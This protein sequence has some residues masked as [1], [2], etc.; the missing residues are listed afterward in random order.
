[1]RCRAKNTQR[2]ETE[3]ET[4]GIFSLFP[5]LSILCSAYT[6][7]IWKKRKKK[8]KSFFYSFIY[9]KCVQNVLLATPFKFLR[10]SDWEA[11]TNERTEWQAAT[12]SRHVCARIWNGY[13]SLA[14]HTHTLFFTFFL[15]VFQRER[16]HTQTCL[17]AIKSKEFG[18]IR[19]S[20]VCAYEW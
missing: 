1:M 17:H 8:Q 7:F 2:E 6:F 20:N 16:G 12:F 14:P 15:S 3:R 18:S 19:W 10:S 9:A 11:I 4:C 13:R 5:F